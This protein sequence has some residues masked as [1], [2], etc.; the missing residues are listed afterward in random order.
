MLSRREILSV[1]GAVPAADLLS[2]GRLYAQAA[3]NFPRR[4]L[5]RTGRSVVPLALGGQASLQWTRPGIDAPDIIVRAIQLGLNYLDTANAYGP[6][7]MNY[8]EAFRRLHLTPPDTNYDAALRQQL[9]VATKTTRR[10]ALDRSSSTPTA[11]DDLKTSLTQIFGDGKGFIPEGAYLDSIQI[12]NLTTVEQVNQIY[13]GFSERDRRQLDRIGAL[14]GLLDYRDGTNYTGLNPEHRH[15]VRHIGLTGHLSSPVLMTAIRRDMES[16]FD[17]VLVAL[18]ANDRLCSSHQNNVLPLA[19]SRG[20]GVIAMKVFADGAFYGKE[21][22]FSR[23]PED[24]ILSVGKPDAIPCS[25]LVRYPLSLPGVSCAIIGT[26]RIDREKPENDQ[27]VANLTAAVKDVASDAERFRIENDAAS[28]HGAATNYFQEKRGLV[29]PSDI[30]IR[31]DGERAVVEWNTALAGPEPIRAY[32]VLSGDRLLLSLPF[33]PQMTEA[34]IA[35]SLPAAAI[36]DAALTVVASEK[37][38]RSPART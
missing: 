34:P 29:Q 30:Q 18:N 26:G 2:P 17:T 1:L 7:Q 36:G 24:V 33:R 4:L 20:L 5:G 13:E 19:V 35:V 6:S 9:F 10:L 15:W 8:G 23:T 32:E 22:R 27:M 25:D 28:L 38:P 37:P 21:P 11:I 14:A 12:H 16:V 3:G 31:R